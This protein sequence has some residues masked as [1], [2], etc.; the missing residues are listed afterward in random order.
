[1]MMRAAPLKWLL[2]GFMVVSFMGRPWAQAVASVPNEDC[3]GMN[4]VAMQFSNSAAGHKIGKIAMEENATPKNE[5]GQNEDCRLRQGL[6]CGANPGHIDR[7]MVP[8]CLAADSCGDYPSRV[9]RSSAKARTHS[10]HS[11]GLIATALAGRRLRLM[12]Q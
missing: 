8:G 6:R 12:P 5:C 1:M 3:G 9:K 7:G 11:A 10:S 2:I 4:A